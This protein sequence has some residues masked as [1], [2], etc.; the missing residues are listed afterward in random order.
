MILFRDIQRSLSKLFTSLSSSKQASNERI[1][2]QVRDTKS[3]II[4]K[5]DFIVPLGTEKP[6]SDH[7]QLDS[8]I[9]YLLQFAVYSYKIKG[10]NTQMKNC[11]R[12]IHLFEDNFEI[13]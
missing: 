9:G 2:I 5:K 8:S 4:S 10:E 7:F 13:Y 3:K 1:E 12:G 6:I 11:F